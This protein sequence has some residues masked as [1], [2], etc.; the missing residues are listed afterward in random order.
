M[1]KSASKS[2]FVL[3]ENFVSPLMCE[4]IIDRLDHTTPDR[5]EKNNPHKTIKFNRLTEIR[6]LPGIEEELVPY[7]EQYYG[8]EHKGISPFE[9]E[10]FPERG[11]VPQ[12]RCENSE[13]VN[14]KWHRVNNHDFVGII[15]LNSQQETVPL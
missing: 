8:Y 6:L 11:T 13:Y 12:A 5:D 14:G 2:P 1:S 7:L 4:D 9:F 3:F 15:F 10:W